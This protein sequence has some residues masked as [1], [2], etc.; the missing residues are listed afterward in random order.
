MMKS[1]LLTAVILSFSVAANGAGIQLGP[2]RIS[3]CSK[4]ESSNCPNSP[5]VKHYVD[6]GC[7]PIHDPQTCCLTGFDCSIF[8]ELK[9]QNYLGCFY[10]GT[11]ITE[12]RGPIP[13]ADPCQECECN[14]A[15]SSPYS[16]SCVVYDCPL[17]MEGFEP[18]CIFKYEKGDCC[19]A[20]KLCGELVTP[21]NEVAVTCTVNGQVYKEGEK[22][23]DFPSRPCRICN[24][25][26]NFV[27]A[28]SPSCYDLDCTVRDV[29]SVSRSCAPIYYGEDSCCPI[30]YH[31]PEGSG[32]KFSE[33]EKN[34][35]Q[36]IF[37]DVHSPI[38]SVL[39]TG[40]PCMTCSCR[41]PPLFTCVKTPGCFD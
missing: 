3:A 32:E 11:K 31:C 23:S 1:V 21:K 37:G 18:G 22:I 40:K 10:N 29:G 19:A 41:V 2:G 14:A 38:G 34:P 12:S 8:Q 27:D 17:E 5:L 28:D 33:F 16:V 39:P 36:C 30:E 9:E 4:E 7:H 6:I 35:K 13:T 15:R 24:C 25:S 26:A 20:D